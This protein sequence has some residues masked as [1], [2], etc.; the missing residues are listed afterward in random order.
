MSTEAD[1]APPIGHNQPPEPTPLEKAKEEISLLDAEAEAWAGTPI[2]N[3]QQAKDVAK[4]L[5]AARKAAKWADDT[6]KEEKK[7]HAE[8]A[9]AVDEAWKPII[10]DA[11]RVVECTKK[12]QTDWLI[13]LDEAK[14]A[15][16]DR[17]RKE[18]DAK[19]A[20]AQRLAAQTDGS[21]EAAKA[22]D[23]AIEEAKKA[24][25]QASR[26]EHDKA[27]AKAD[28]M[29][30]AIGLRTI[31]KAKVEDRRALLNHIATTDAQ[32]LIAFVEDWAAKEVRRGARS[33]PGVAVIE[34]KAAA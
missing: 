9:K 26:A 6:R 15:E 7:P 10:A 20:E 8:A 19:Q 24:E 5:D 13:K 2:E 30:R 12:A 1:T 14:R 31:Y 4:L 29:G 25:K 16:A 3:E 27:G 22:R 18:A 17:Q 32:A 21:V 33:I 23:V 28:G 34:E 11:N